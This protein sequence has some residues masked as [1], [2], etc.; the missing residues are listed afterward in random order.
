MMATQSTHHSLTQT[1][2]SDS[3][4]LS[5]DDLYAA[6]KGYARMMTT[7]LGLDGQTVYWGSMNPS[8]IK[9]K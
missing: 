3:K 2:L 7:T 9:Y 6:A 8:V 1:R 5:K 4:P